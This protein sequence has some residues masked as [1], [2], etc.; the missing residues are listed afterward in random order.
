MNTDD[1]YLELG[2]GGKMLKEFCD[3]YSREVGINLKS[4]D[5]STDI[6]SSTEN[7]ILTINAESG[8][9]EIK[10]SR[11]E[12]EDYPGGAENEKTK[13]KIKQA[14]NDIT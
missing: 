7:H 9:T 8:V 4:V 6:V 5:W 10:F 12:I 1:I 14:I 13:S 11:E 2:E 3:T